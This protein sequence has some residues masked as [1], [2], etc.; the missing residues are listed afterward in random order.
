MQMG[1]C[2]C[3]WWGKKIVV[4]Q[5]PDNLLKVRSFSGGYGPGSPCTVPQTLVKKQPGVVL[6]M[7]VTFAAGR[8]HLP[9]VTLNRAA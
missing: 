3:R 6:E 8:R 5:R 1:N 9:R 2:N 7:N 4:E